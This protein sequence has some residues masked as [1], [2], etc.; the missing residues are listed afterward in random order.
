MLRVVFLT[1]SFEGPNVE[2]AS[3]SLVKPAREAEPQVKFLGDVSKEL[4]AEILLTTNFMAQPAAA[5][6]CFFELRNSRKTR[7]SKAE[8]RAFPRHSAFFVVSERS[9]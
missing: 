2:R 7:K 3:R 4:K 5:A 1:G 8:A 9:L 6:N